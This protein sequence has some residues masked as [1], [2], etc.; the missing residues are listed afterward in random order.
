VISFE[1]RQILCLLLLLL[2]LIFSHR[3]EHYED[4]NTTYKSTSV[5]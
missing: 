2:L 1:D 4:F 3:L 5:K